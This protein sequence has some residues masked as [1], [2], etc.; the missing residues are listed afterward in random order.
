M[1]GFPLLTVF[2]TLLERIITKVSFLVL[3]LSRDL[4]QVGVKSY[5]RLQQFCHEVNDF[6]H[7][8]SNISARLSGG[9]FYSPS[10]EVITMDKVIGPVEVLYGIRLNNLCVYGPHISIPPYSLF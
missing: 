7:G 3:S 4:F 6:I 5:F 8:S 9:S 1:T 10:F 2:P